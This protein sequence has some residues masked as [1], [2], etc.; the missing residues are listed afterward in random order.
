MTR[1]LLKG[2]LIFSISITVF[3]IAINVW[4]YCGHRQ[5]LKKTRPLFEKA[6]SF[7]Y[8]H[9]LDSARYYF[10]TCVGL[11]SGG[12][13]P[14]MESESSYWVAR[15]FYEKESI[16][17]FD[18]IQYYSKRSYRSGDGGFFAY[19]RNLKAARKSHFL[20]AK[21]YEKRS[22]YMGANEEYQQ[23]IKSSKEFGD[24]PGLI[25][26]VGKLA[27]FHRRREDWYNFTA[28]FLDNLGHIEEST[29][30]KYE[31]ELLP[32]V[33]DYYSFAGKYSPELAAEGINVSRENLPQFSI[34]ID[35]TTDV[36]YL[37]SFG[38]LLSL[39]ALARKDSVDYIKRAVSFQKDVLALTD[40]LLDRE[41]KVDP[42]LSL[43][44][45]YLALQYPDSA[46]I[47]LEGLPSEIL[48]W[49]P[50]I[51][52]NSLTASANIQKGEYSVAA[53]YLE[54]TDTVTQRFWSTSTLDSFE[55]VVSM[56]EHYRIYMKVLEELG[57]DENVVEVSR[58]FVEAYEEKTE[59]GNRLSLGNIFEAVPHI[60]KKY[61]SLEKEKIEKKSWQ[62]S[63][64]GLFVILVLVVG[65]ASIIVFR[66]NEVS[67]KKQ[68]MEKALGLSFQNIKLK[69]ANKTRI[70]KLSEIVFIEKIQFTNKV[71]FHTKKGEQ[72]ES[73]YTL[74]DL[75]N[76]N[77]VKAI[78]QLPPQFFVRT[79]A[80]YLINLLEV[81]EIQMGKNDTLLIVMS[82][83][84]RVNGSRD[85]RFGVLEAFE[86]IQRGE[87]NGQTEP[88]SLY[89]QFEEWFNSQKWIK[90]M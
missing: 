16:K 36:E 72:L 56:V 35:T 78:G 67:K 26:S 63:T 69:K 87:F 68:D 21:V 10:Q 44:E 90:G 32:I 31:R 85:R 76:G 7:Y 27:R 70:L 51:R 60:F 49:V 64:R 45:L 39:Q 88:P 82:N 84:Y 22:D 54:D 89:Q 19:K 75:E 33:S 28:V 29:L 4:D 65:M 80:T 57:H 37:I 14:A 83:D 18:S 17:G 74:N 77:D 86:K 25:E 58:H 59:L 61:E 52:K 53:S 23:A 3:V 30:R 20:R 24:V 43:S 6:Q 34:G 48:D 55:F 79:H 12:N 42:A 81:K 47:T 62:V 15:C 66:L 11:S 2:V 50:Y 9:N 73:D 71:M 1:K 41:M 46:L 5:T 38:Q 8:N 40:S 13:S